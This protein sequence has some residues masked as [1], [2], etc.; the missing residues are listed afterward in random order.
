MPEA[1]LKY[2]VER[3]S[4][5]TLGLYVER[6]GSVLVRA[7]VST[8]DERIAATVRARSK[9]I[10]R[11]QAR[12]AEL[13]PQQAQREFVSG[14]TVYFLG[15]PHRLDFRPDARRGLKQ[16]GDIFVMHVNDRDR[17]EELLKAYYRTEG[18]TRLPILVRQHAASMALAPGPVRVLELGHRWGSCSPKGALNFH[19]KALAVP[20]EVLHYLVVHE[21]AH[22]AQRDHSLQFWRTVE[23]EMPGWQAHAKWLAEHGAQMT[24]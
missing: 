7:P 2:T 3:S 16:Q 1:L 18:L 15:Q 5:K 17:A 20:L 12:W 14:E 13:N 9:W 10:F 19:W 11:A 22:L 6:D 24:L 8:S 23:A 21:L 4:R